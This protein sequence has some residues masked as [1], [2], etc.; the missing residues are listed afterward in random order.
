MAEGF[1]ATKVWGNDGT[2]SRV[3][4]KS[5]YQHGETIYFL[6]PDCLFAFSV[7]LGNFDRFS[8]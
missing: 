7:I 6:A 8:L 3:T 2:P 5:M 4:S 1:T